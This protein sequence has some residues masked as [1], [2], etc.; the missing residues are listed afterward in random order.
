MFDAASIVPADPPFWV[1]GRAAA[2]AGG[3]DI[4]L[5]MA[6]DLERLL[7]SVGR[8]LL[9]CLTRDKS[10]PSGKFL[11][12]VLLAGKL[13]P[14]GAEYPPAVDGSGPPGR[15]KEGL[16]SGEPLPLPL[17]GADGLKSDGKALSELTSGNANLDRLLLSSLAVIGRPAP[18]LGTS[19]AEGSKVA[20]WAV[21]GEFA[22][23]ET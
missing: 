1:G 11:E 8:R 16:N 19:P 7:P 2:A 10:D 14:G 5:P 23:G 18:V 21:S 12:P 20:C 6:N 22:L 9:L 13:P 17:P 4:E 15:P 3:R